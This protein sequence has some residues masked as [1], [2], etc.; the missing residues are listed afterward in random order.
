DG[1]TAIAA[2]M[3]IFRGWL[4]TRLWNA[5]VAAKH[6]AGADRWASLLRQMAAGEIVISALISEPG[7]DLL[8]PMVEAT[9][10]QGG[11]LLKGIKIFGTLSPAADLFQVAFRMTNDTGEERRA[12]ALV[13]SGTPGLEI[14]NNWDALGM[15]GSGSHDVVLK[16]CFVPDGEPVD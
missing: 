13:P 8:H 5:A 3:H 10:S 1:S 15:R 2:N 6:P 9:R 11:W 12:L 14:K 4:F 16:D 7:T